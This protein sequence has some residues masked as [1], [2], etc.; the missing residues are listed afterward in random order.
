MYHSRAS[1]WCLRTAL[2]RSVQRT[3]C[4]RSK[5]LLLPD[6]PSVL[7]KDCTWRD[8]QYKTLGHQV[9]VCIV[10]DRF[11]SSSTSLVE[12]AVPRFTVLDTIRSRI[13][14]ESSSQ[15]YL[16]TDSTFGIAFPQTDSL[17]RPQS[18]SFHDHEFLEFRALVPSYMQWQGVHSGRVNFALS[19]DLMSLVRHLLV[20]NI[21]KRCRVIVNEK[22]RARKS[23]YGALATCLAILEDTVAFARVVK[24]VMLV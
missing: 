2:E 20:S 1:T 18:S 4:D 7:V 22:L 21:G 23:E 13:G 17:S 14:S 24:Y 5:S 15:R 16:S 9:L 12:S 10:S 19:V 8:G 6:L 3:Y 11:S